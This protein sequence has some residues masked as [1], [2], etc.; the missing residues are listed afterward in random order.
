MRRRDARPWRWLAWL[1]LLPALV[2]GC[3]KR[4]PPW[5]HVAGTV[6]L[7]GSPAKDVTVVFQNAEM[8]VHVT[9]NTNAAGEFEMRT[10][11][12]PG[13]PAGKYAIAV[14]PTYADVP[15]EGLMLQEPKPKPNCDVPQRY[16]D[17]TT[18]GL[19]AAVREGE[20]R[21]GFDLK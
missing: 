11:E 6:T 2:C 4:L 5:G 7:A 14:L 8:G 10:A 20:N 1:L 9:A 21:F 16:Q 18:S 17:A 3:G 13:L 19:T 15:H 12:F